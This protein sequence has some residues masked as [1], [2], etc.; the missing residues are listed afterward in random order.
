VYIIAHVHFDNSLETGVP[1][2]DRPCN[3]TY[4]PTYLLRNEIQH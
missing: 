3:T 4:L 2:R 1:K